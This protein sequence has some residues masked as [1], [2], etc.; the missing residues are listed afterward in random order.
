M[1]VRLFRIF[2]VFSKEGATYAVFLGLFIIISLTGGTT[3][4]IGSHSEKTAYI[5]TS[6]F[7]LLAFLFFV[8]IIIFPGKLF[9]SENTVCYKRSVRLRRI[10]AS[11]IVKNRVSRRVSFTVSNIRDIEFLQNPIERFFN[12]GRLRFSGDTEYEGNIPYSF[13]VP[14]R[15]YHTVCGIP[16]FRQ[17]QKDID[18]YINSR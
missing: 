15:E 14:E 9:I 1:T 11:F 4:E 2:N 12:V 10:D 16:N 5:L 6:S 3:A 13:E 7:W 17:F 8:F 18:K